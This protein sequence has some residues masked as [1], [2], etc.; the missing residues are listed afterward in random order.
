[1]EDSNT[2]EMKMKYN[3]ILYTMLPT[4]VLLAAVACSKQSVGTG[5]FP[6]DGV[7]RINASVGETF[8]RADGDKAYEGNTLGLFIDYGTHDSYTK[9]NTSWTRAAAG[10]WA[11]TDGSMLLWK[12][13]KTVVDIYAYAPYQD[14]QNDA[15]A[16]VFN[17]PTDQ[18]AG[19]G[20]ADAVIYRKPSLD[21]RTELTGDGMLNI[22]FR[23]ALAR[24]KVV[25]R[26]GN[27]FDGTG[28]TITSVKFLAGGKSATLNLK[29]DSVATG[30]SYDD[31]FLMHD[32][33]DENETAF[34]VVSW[35][36]RFVRG[37]N[38][39][40]VTMS[41]G[42]T[43][44]AA[45]QTTLS[46]GYFKSGYSYTINVRLGK[47][48]I[49]LEDDIQVSEWVVDTSGSLDDQGGEAEIDV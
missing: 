31:E 20:A 4:A 49:E 23:H 37:W 32:C 1:M 18:S 38:L 47:D 11:T 28:I 48:K 44:T 41:D 25:F 43:Y 8:T 40:A 16:V 5:S 35:P 34:E 10:D 24:F 42:Q 33:S 36:N 26:F 6:E 9:A 15:S 2:Q 45:A 27:Q 12:D 30:S 14:G 7:V 46:S 29:D 13:S 21:P 19:I 3:P 39:L 17:I 22:A